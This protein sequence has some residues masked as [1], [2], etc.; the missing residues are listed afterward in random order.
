MDKV[1]FVGMG[2]VGMTFASQFLDSGCPVGFL[3]DESRKEKARARKFTVNGRPYAFQVLTLS[4]VRG[5]PAFLFVAVK[6]YQLES[7]L[8]LIQE[9]AGPETVVLSLLNGIDSE[10][11]IAGR[12]GEK[13][14]L[15][16]FVSRMDSTR[17]ADGV[18]YSSPGQIV[19]GERN[20]SLTARVERVRTLL[21][22]A[23]ILHEASDQIMRKMWWK[24]M[25]NVGINQA[26]AILKA[27]YGHFQG[28]SPCREVAFAAMRE[29]IALAPFSGIEL[30]EKDIEASVQML[31]HFN[32]EGKNSMLQDLESG[33]KTEVEI[34]AGKVCRLGEKA[35]VPTPV[36][37]LFYNMLK[38]IEWQK[39]GARKG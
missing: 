21:S 22:K 39:E 36:N 18:V 9:V 25:V 4:E 5:A 30:S 38:T 10:E 12:L 34:F 28:F 26:G 24:F 23:G 6:E 20:G 2:A 19:F 33:R 37:R 17:E 7:A 1:I 16:A 32:P 3:C 15:P 29:V 13:S 27:P 35:G 11:I 31:K 8:D 14:V